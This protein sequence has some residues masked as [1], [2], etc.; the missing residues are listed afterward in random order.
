[1]VMILDGVPSDFIRSTD[2]ANPDQQ[3]DVDSMD[4]DDNNQEQPPLLPPEIQSDV[5]S[6][7]QPPL[8][9]PEIQSDVDTCHLYLKVSSNLFLD[10]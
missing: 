3:S 7:E 8:L 9:L 1:M 2:Q 5:D 4:D 6:M 10:I